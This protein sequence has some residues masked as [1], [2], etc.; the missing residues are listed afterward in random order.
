MDVIQIQEEKNEV[1][2]KISELLFDFSKRTGVVVSDIDLKK[3]ATV[4]GDVVAYDV[5]IEVKL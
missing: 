5:N 2:Q 4:G 1:E 3:F